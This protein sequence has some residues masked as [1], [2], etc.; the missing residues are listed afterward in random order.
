[1]SETIKNEN[2]NRCHTIIKGEEKER[3]QDVWSCLNSDAKAS[4]KMRWSKQAT[5]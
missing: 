1:M 5:K 3:S 2:E 4:V